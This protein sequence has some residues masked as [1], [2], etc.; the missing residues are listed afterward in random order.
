MLPGGR[1]RAPPASTRQWK[2][3]DWGELTNIKGERF[4]SD[5]RSRGG[6]MSIIKG[7]KKCKLPQ[8][9]DTDLQITKKRAERPS[10][11]ARA[12]RISDISRL[13]SPHYRW[14][15]QSYFK[16]GWRLWHFS[17]GRNCPV[18]RNVSDNCRCDRLTFSASRNGSLVSQNN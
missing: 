5:F 12:R 17:W 3:F 6:G 1:A 2:H 4:K 7:K 15:A 16:G 13:S 18:D 11:S 14:G 8:L 9:H 10:L